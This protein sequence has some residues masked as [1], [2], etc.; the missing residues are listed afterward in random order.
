[1][2]S[3]VSKGSRQ[4]KSDSG[5]KSLSL[6]RGKPS[7][8][9]S[10][11]ETKNKS[12][13]TLSLTPL[14]MTTSATSDSSNGD[15]KQSRVSLTPSSKRVSKTVD[16]S[17]SNLAAVANRSM[18]AS[19]KIIKIAADFWNTKMSKLSFEEQKEIGVTMYLDMMVSDKSLRAL[20]A[21]RFNGTT[22]I[23]SIS[24]KFFNMLG[25]LIRT[26][27]RN[28]DNVE[29][30]LRSLG[31][32]HKNFG[33]DNAHFAVMLASLHTTFA[34]YFPQDY[35][36]KE[37]Y[38]LDYMF[39]L[40]SQLMMGSGS[41][42]EH[43]PEHQGEIRVDYMFTLAS[44]LMMG[45][46]STTEH[47]PETEYLNNLQTCLRSSVGRAYLFRY[48]QQTWCDELVIYSQNIQKFEQ[49]TNDKGRFMIARNIVEVSINAQ[50][51]LAVNISY[52]CRQNALELMQEYEQQFQL[53]QD[54]K[55]SA[56][57]FDSVTSEIHALIMSNH[58]N[59]FKRSIK[60]MNVDCK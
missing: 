60:T 33:I 50:S 10:N 48:W 32:M 37:R 20:F 28:D 40:A 53:K 6:K 16:Q 27:C 1:M 35:G 42:T 7:N 13:S 26:C 18:Y 22:N 30:T 57:M 52:N 47:S 2:G 17:N 45:G 38:A 3:P 51:D 19:D 9:D 43:S 41:T 25:W 11:N 12:M 49:Q 36:I 44:Q 31:A 14:E 21:R 29:N 55:V 8:N 15:T 54:I 34:H 46:A 59:T 5:S 39:T 24:L 23:E 4:A 58:W 56:K